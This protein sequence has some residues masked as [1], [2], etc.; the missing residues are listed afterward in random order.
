MGYFEELYTW[1]TPV[2]PI[3]SAELSKNGGF[4]SD[5]HLSITKLSL[6]ANF[7][8][9]LKLCLENRAITMTYDFA[10]N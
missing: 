1:G 3:F 5:I 2:P 10:E 8:T 4:Q 6:Y 7:Q 9:F